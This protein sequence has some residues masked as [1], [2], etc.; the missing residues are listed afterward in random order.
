[1]QMEGEKREALILVADDD[2]DILE[3]V[4]LRLEQA[5][6]RALRARDGE[7]ALRLAREQEPDLCVLDVL[8]P[9][10]NGFEVIRELRRNG[11]DVPVLLLTAT[12]Q[13]KDVARGFEI[14]AD[15][16]LRKPFDPTEL[17][18]RVEALLK[19]A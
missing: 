17:Q 2:P 9:R 18:A 3:L 19:S 6:Y 11:A 14:G 16:Y 8:M 5:G 15:D 7:E 10:L 12:V 13:E 4:G 1:M